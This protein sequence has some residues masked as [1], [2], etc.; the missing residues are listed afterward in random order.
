MYL[1]RFADF[2]L[3]FHM[4]DFLHLATGVSVKRDQAKQCD[5]FLH[6]SQSPVGEQVVE[7]AYHQIQLQQVQQPWVPTQVP[8]AQPAVLDTALELEGLVA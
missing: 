8:Y 5:K 7:L 1:N 4:A 3:T 6:V 2:F